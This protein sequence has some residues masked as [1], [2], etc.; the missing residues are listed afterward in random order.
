[1]LEDQVVTERQTATFVCTL[2][3]PKLKVTWYKN[4]Q[5]L[6]ENDRIQFIQDGKNYKLVIDNSQLDDAA[7]YKIKFGDD[8]E[9]KAELIVKGKQI[10]KFLK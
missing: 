3:K 1:M 2:S 10:I 6:N 5:K 8:C 4:N 9:S 7:T